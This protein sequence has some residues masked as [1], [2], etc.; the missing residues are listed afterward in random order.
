[1]CVYESL[2]CGLL[3]LFFKSYY[4]E[5]LIEI[6]EQSVKK[7]G[8]MPLTNEHLLNILKMVDKQ[9]EQEEYEQDMIFDPNW[10]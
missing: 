8:V 1:M 7:N 6:L 4:M 5:K 9:L 2:G 10:D 3:G